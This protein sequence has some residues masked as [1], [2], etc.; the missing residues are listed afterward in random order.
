[1]KSHCKYAFLLAAGTALSL[2]SALAAPLSVEQYLSQ[3]E[4]QSPAVRGSDASARG[5]ELLRNSGD[6]V[7]TPTLTA[8]WRNLEDKQEYPNPAFQGSLTK[9]NQYSVGLAMNTPIGLAGA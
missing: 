3:V 8:N 2:A 1:M 4:Q 6:V 9:G 7:T 5:Y